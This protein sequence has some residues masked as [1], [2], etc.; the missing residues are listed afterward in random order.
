MGV[1]FEEKSKN[2]TQLNYLTNTTRTK[3]CGA[4]WGGGCNLF[5]KR[6]PFLHSNIFPS[7]EG[8]T[9]G[10]LWAG[11]P[12]ARA[13]SFNFC[14]PLGYKLRS[15]NGFTPPS[16]DSPAAFLHPIPNGAQSVQ[17]AN[18]S[19]SPG[20]A[21]AILVTLVTRTPTP[22][23]MA[24]Q[25]AQ[26]GPN[27]P[28]FQHPSSLNPVHPESSPCFRPVRLFGAT[29]SPTLGSPAVSGPSCYP[30]FCARKRVVCT[31]WS[32]VFFGISMTDVWN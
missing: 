11:L 24:T 18:S 8:S 10:R 9:A 4:K 26:T 25:L 15:L 31:T 27:I 13:S 22:V 17:S 6:L 7:H 3:T 20:P 30:A 14:Q 23:R 5:G 32:G 16:M 12:S 2:R 28:S 21:S 19:G 1:L 29:L